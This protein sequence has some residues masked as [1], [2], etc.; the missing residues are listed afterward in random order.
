MAGLLLH[1]KDGV[2]KARCAR[3]GGLC[4][5]PRSSNGDAVCGGCVGRTDRRRE[6]VPGGVVSMWNREAYERYADSP[7]GVERQK[8]W[9]RE[10]LAMV[11]EA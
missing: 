11:D 5:V 7:A 2:V 3:C 8:Q 4:A 9:Q 1:G 6:Y 10:M